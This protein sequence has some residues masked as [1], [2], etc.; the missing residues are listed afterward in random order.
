MKAMIPSW[1]Y[2]QFDADFSLEFP[3]EGYG[4]WKQ[5]SLPIDTDKTALVIMHAW[6]AGSR[7]E[8]PG[9]HRAV[10]YIPRSYE[11]ANGVLK[12]ILATARAHG[13]KIYHVV[14]DGTYY[15]EMPGYR[16]AAELA[17]E[18]FPKL[19]Q[20]ESDI[21]R[22]ERNA[23]KSAKSFP[24]RH[25]QADVDRGFGQ[26]GFI[27]SVLPAGVE[28]IVKN[29]EQLFAVAAADGVNHLIY[30]GF[31]INYCLQ[32]S[33]AG[34]LDMGRRGF[35]CSAIRQATTAVE[36]KESVRHEEHKEYALWLTAMMFG[37]VYD[38]EDVIKMIAALPA[39][40]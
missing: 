3:G 40:E 39:H 16:Y 33:P 7:D 29:A 34:M 4:G 35:T 26:L 15:R 10:E 11:I 21:T 37:F 24:G 36:R 32:Y 6:D 20:A 5:T 31:A 27:Q 9:W 28:P 38:A 14:G 1:Y 22:L 2:Q 25:N 17:G 18:D 30:S 13:L 12:D 23:F 8:F 19:P